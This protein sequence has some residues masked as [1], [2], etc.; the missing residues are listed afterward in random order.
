[1]VLRDKPGIGAETRERVLQVAR[2]LGYERRIPAPGSRAPRTAAM[3]LRTRVDHPG[4]QNPSVNPFYGNVISGLEAAART[5]RI[6][7]LYGTLP[8]D[9]ANHPYEL[10]DHLLGQQLDA[11]LLIGA[12]AEETIETIAAGRSGPIVLVDGPTGQSPHDTVASD[13]QGGT[14]L[15]VRHLV[16]HGHRRI[17]MIGTDL[18]A[19]PNLSQR[20]AGYL[21]A[22]AEAGLEPLIVQTHRVRAHVVTDATVDLLAAHPDVTA[23]VGANDAAAIEAMRGAQRAGREVPT[24]LSVI[25]FDDIVLASEI[26]PALTTMAV[27]RITMGRQAIRLL[28]D[29]LDTPGACRIMSV[30]QPTLTIRESTGNAPISAPHSAAVTD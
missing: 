26:R 30:L 15:A 22:L 20:R 7:L 27:D 5:S 11:V 13:N 29:R 21:Q 16:E 4:L 6:N 10:P 19:D 18:D 14:L 17:A 12:F 25:G 28:V 1:M 23:I 8:V 3:I 2:E 24:D 9:P